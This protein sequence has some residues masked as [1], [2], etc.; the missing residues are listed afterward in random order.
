MKFN[1]FYKCKLAGILEIGGLTVSV[2]I[3][4][5]NEISKIYHTIDKVTQRL[6]SLHMWSYIFS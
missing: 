4:V 1:T 2:T 3:T 5:E 6:S